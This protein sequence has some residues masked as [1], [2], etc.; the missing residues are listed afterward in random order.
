MSTSAKTLDEAAEMVV[1][2]RAKTT[3][4]DGFVPD[5]K[6]QE[7]AKGAAKEKGKARSRDRQGLD[8]KTLIGLYR[9]MYLSRRIDDKEIQ[10]KGQNKIFF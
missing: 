8:E 4:A 1:A 7:T 2:E 6:V 10:M 3:E 5:E 9:T